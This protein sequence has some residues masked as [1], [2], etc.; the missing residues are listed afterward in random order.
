MSSARG[1]EAGF[2]LLEVLVALAILG[3]TL[4]LAA[5]RGGRR[6]GDP[7]AAVRG[8]V[9]TLAEARGRALDGARIERL[10]AA[11]LTRDLPAG[12]RL[13]VDGPLPIRFYPDGSASGATLELAGEGG[14]AR[15]RIDPLTGRAGPTD[16]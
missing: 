2:T 12:L 7:G 5:P 1:A 4:L 15:L 6:D 9:A 11:R 8:L 13:A 10:D 3:L 16:G 14:R